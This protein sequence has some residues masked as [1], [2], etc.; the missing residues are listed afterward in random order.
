V[1]ETLSPI[2]ETGIKIID[3]FVPLKRGGQLGLFTP[4]SGVGKMVL[5]NQLIYRLAAFHKGYI[6][7][8]GLEE[9]EFT[10]ASMIQA[11]R[12]E[13][14]LKENILEDRVVF[15]FGQANGPV[16]EQ[17]Q[18]AETGLTLAESFRQ[19]GHEVLLVVDSQL[20]LGEGVVPYLRTYAVATPEAAI[21]T[22]YH[23]DYTVGLEPAPLANL[24]AVITFDLQRAMQRL[25]PAVDPLRSYSRLMQPE[26]IG[27]DHVEVVAQ[28]RRLLQRYG[29]LHYQVE[30]YGLDSLF[31]LDQRQ[32]DETIVGQARRLHRFLTQPFFGTEPWTGMPGQYVKLEEALA[33]CQAILAGQTDEWP[34]EALYFVGTLEQ[35]ARKSGN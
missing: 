34:E 33:G 9:G 22:L 32:E 25:Y 17:Q 16:Q 19:Q 5:I 30:K 11:W 27:Q 3:L 14:G 8:L 7:Y 6:V 24:D 35:A 21:T 31:Y 15:V 28:A 13:F 18:A 20:A 4:L 2:L 12:G 10:A 23:G 26:L 29:E 1:S